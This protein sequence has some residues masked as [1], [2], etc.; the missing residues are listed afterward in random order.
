MR[1]NL[2]R[3]SD[4]IKQ[5]KIDE[6]NDL[7]ELKKHFSQIQKGM[8]MTSHVMDS[9]LKRYGVIQYD[10]KGEK[11]NPQSHEAVF[12]MQDP[13]MENNTVG[14]VMQTGWKIGDRVLRAAKVGVVKK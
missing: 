6:Q 3:A 10:P 5:L 7:T 4:F 9:T 12:M 2:E 13:V 11:F 8:E 1:D 14:Q